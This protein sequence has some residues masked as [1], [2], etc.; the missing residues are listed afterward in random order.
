MFATVVGS[1]TGQQINK[2]HVAWQGESVQRRMD[3]VKKAGAIC[4]LH[5]K[6]RFAEP[7]AQAQTLWKKVFRAHARS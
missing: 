5:S 6:R 2:E 1:R 4:K 7:H 3:W